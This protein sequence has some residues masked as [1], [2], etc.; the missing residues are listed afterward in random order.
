MLAA[1]PGGASHTDG[2]VLGRDGYLLS[3][4]RGGTHEARETQETVFFVSFTSA[5]QA[6]NLAKA[7]SELKGLP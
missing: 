6:R 1:C 2:Q 4:R 5:D 3:A 7:L